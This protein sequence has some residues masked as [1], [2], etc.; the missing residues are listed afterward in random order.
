M[1]AERRPS[2]EET[3]EVEAMED[4]LEAAAEKIQAVTAPREVT[5]TMRAMEGTAAEAATLIRTVVAKRARGP[6][7]R[8]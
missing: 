5:M 4:L 3:A 2:Q 8:V 7:D 1:T 6:T